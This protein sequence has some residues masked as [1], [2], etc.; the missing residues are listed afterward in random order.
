MGRRLLDVLHVFQGS[1]VFF[2]HLGT[3]FPSTDIVWLCG[4]PASSSWNSGEEAVFCSQQ[5]SIRKLDSG[6]E[7]LIIHQQEYWKAA[8]DKLVE[9]GYVSW[10]EILATEVRELKPSIFSYGFLSENHS[11]NR[12]LIAVEQTALRGIV[13]TI[14]YGALHT[15]VDIQ[16]A[17]G[18]VSRGQAHGRVR[19]L[20]AAK[21]L[22]SYVYHSRA[23]GF[24]FPLSNTSWRSFSGLPIHLTADFDASLGNSGD[25]FQQRRLA[26]D[27]FA[28]QGVLLFVQV[29]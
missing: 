25:V 21:V 26:A 12:E 3:K 27:G 2:G 1:S 22:T 11:S 15:R 5:V 10:D 20:Q 16:A 24:C 19:H 28:R 18:Q 23:L 6:E 29:G 13:N 14:S 8:F 17:V 9:K 4:N 7:F